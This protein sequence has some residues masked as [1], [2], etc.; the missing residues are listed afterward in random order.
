MKRRTDRQRIPVDAITPYLMI[1]V[2]YDKNEGFSSHD[3]PWHAFE[4]DDSRNCL[5]FLS[6]IVDVTRLGYEDRDV[7]VR[8]S[9]NVMFWG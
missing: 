8:G 1:S 9:G 3:A 5:T 2:F 7:C 6:K 4:W